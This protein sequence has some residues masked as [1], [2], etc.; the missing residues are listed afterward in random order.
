MAGIYIHIPYCRHKCAYCDFFSASDHRNIDETGRYLRAVVEE[1]KLR[2]NELGGAPLTTLYIGGGTPSVIPL[3]KLAEFMREIAIYIPLSSLEEV[4]IEANPED[5]TE[6]SIAA[7]RAMGFNR[8]SVGVQSFLPEELSSIDRR[9]SPEASR[10]ALEALSA[11]GINYSADLIYGLPGQ[12]PERWQENLAELLAFRPPHFSAY[13]LSYEQGT[14]L[15]IMREKGIVAEA[16]EQMAQRFFSILCEEA[17]RHGYHHYEISNLAIPDMEA[18]HN[19]S[20][21][22]Y[23]PYLGLGAAA[24]SFDGITRR[25][26]P[27]NIKKYISSIEAGL[28][29]FAVDE[30]DEDNRLNDYI[31]TSLRTTDGLD[32]AFVESRFGR[33]S[34]N[35]LMHNAA[36]LLATGNI[37]RNNGHL[38]IPRRLWLLSDS[39][40]RDLIL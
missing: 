14:R 24:H 6:E 34:L 8:I 15:Y 4:T 17:D 21:W 25:Y 30:E 11:S 7:Y 16:T 37:E 3:D 20:Y 10:R 33:I 32:P 12:T 31:I 18:R 39:I 36:P 9:H 26:N 35:R 29:A 19:S 40:F 5:I 27:L 1:W 38:L 2:R 13:L 28:T 22:H 23:T